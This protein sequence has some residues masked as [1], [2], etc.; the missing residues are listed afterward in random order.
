MKIQRGIQTG[1][2]KVVLYGPEGIG[3]S[4]FGAQ[5]PAPL[6]LDVEGGTRH[7]DV[8]RVDPPPASWTALLETVREF[9]REGIGE[10]ATLVL[11]TAD[12]AE[13][14]CVKYICN[15]N[16]KAGVEDFGYGKGYVYLAE[17]F[18]HLLNLMTEVIDAGANVVVLAHA[19][20]RKFEQPDEMGAYDRWE[21][22]L[23]KQVAPLVKEWADMLLFANYK[24]MV[25]TTGEGKNLKAK[26]QG[27]GRR[28]IYTTH[29]ACWDAKN[30]H[31]LADELPLDY[32]PIAHCIP[33]G[34]TPARKE[35]EKEVP[36]PAEAPPSPTSPAAPPEAPDL[37][38]ALSQVM[39]QSQ[40]TEEEVRD[41]IGSLGHFPA[42]T[43]W[44][45]LEEKGYI[46]GYILPQWSYFV[47][48]IA[49]NPH[50]I[51]F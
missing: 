2:Q 14:M 30:R 50:R 13:Q 16:Q 35:A 8:A 28:V 27:Q 12:W 23:S 18:G 6:F 24:T 38:A 22:K 10:F 40:V 45:V 41:V 3:K 19:K 29:H 5:F 51:P 42:E 15:K 44:S 43:P 37:P 33:A 26:A 4:T 39:E 20:M 7:M 11:D 1:P 47:Q 46:D 21:L 36:R 34:P 31:G 32:G 17:E 49:S 25:V 48:T 9:L